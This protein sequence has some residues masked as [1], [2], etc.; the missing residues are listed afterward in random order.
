MFYWFYVTR[1]HVL[2]RVFQKGCIYSISHCR[3]EIVKILRTLSKQFESQIGK[4]LRN[5]SLNYFSN[6]LINTNTITATTTSTP[7]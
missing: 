1:N 7:Q 2:I 3:A 6:I 4:T 5:S